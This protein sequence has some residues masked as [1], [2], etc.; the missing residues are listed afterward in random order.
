[1]SSSAALVNA[2]L[3]K[4]CRRPRAP[5]MRCVRPA[6]DNLC[7]SAGPCRQDQM[8]QYHQVRVSDQL[9]LTGLE[10][11]AP[12]HRRGGQQVEDRADADGNLESDPEAIQAG[13][14]VESA[15]EQPK[16]QQ[17]EECADARAGPAKGFLAY[18]VG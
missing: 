18:A 11:T 13:A 8:R 17:R 5:R 7:S 6:P 16:G 1:M 14:A 12:R 15:D 3:R 10:N 9:L 2:A 4:S